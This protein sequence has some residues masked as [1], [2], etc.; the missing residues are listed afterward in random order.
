MVVY[1][2]VALETSRYLRR[3]CKDSGIW[4]SDFMCGGD[5]LINVGKPRHGPACRLG[6]AEDRGVYFI[7]LT[8]NNYLIMQCVRD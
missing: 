7:Y 3:G 8:K 4:A 2:A 5:Y 6:V 1:I